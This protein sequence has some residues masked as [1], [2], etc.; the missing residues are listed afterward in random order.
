M[1]QESLGQEPATPW[2][3]HTPV[4]AALQSRESLELTWAVQTQQ[5]SVSKAKMK[6]HQ[7]VLTGN[8]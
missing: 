5:D 8:E 4:T 2:W 6:N 7:N 3:Q 1:H